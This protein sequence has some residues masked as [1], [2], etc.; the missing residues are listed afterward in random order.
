MTRIENISRDAPD[1]LLDLFDNPV[2][3]IFLG[4]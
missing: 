2:G 4:G 3:L 1:G